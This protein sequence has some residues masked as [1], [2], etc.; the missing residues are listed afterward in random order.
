M[1]PA[2]ANA[3]A[4]PDG[5]SISVYQ[6]RPDI[7]K[8]RIAIEVH[9][10]GD[11]PVT[12]TAA[13]LESNFFAEGFAPGGAMGT[14]TYSWRFQQE[15]CGVACLVVTDGVSG[16]AYLPAVVGENVTHVWKQPGTYHVELT[17]TDSEGR[18]AVSTRTVQV[19]AP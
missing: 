5:V 16:P 13:T 7:P 14:V 18:T 10:D 6:P 2:P 17:A 15:G 4:P 19:K 8:N 9:N 1:R 11:E 12:I 3:G